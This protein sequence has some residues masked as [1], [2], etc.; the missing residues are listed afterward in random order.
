MWRCVWGW[1]RGGHLTGFL[2]PLC[3][4]SQREWPGNRN[5]W[6]YCSTERH[7][8]EWR[9]QKCSQA[10]RISKKESSRQQWKGSSGTERSLSIDKQRL[11]D[12]MI[13]SFTQSSLPSS[14]ILPYPHRSSSSSASTRGPAGLLSDTVGSQTLSN[15]QYSKGYMTDHFLWIWLTWVTFGHPGTLAGL[16]LNTALEVKDSSPD[17]ATQDLWCS[18][19]Q[20]ASLASQRSHTFS[21]QHPLHHVSLS[22]YFFLF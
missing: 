5:S 21:L 16:I 6:R 20:G 22:T 7:R 17:M 14:Q 18:S 8:A 2:L 12:T 1:G 19:Y 10:S 9:I 4:Q 15:S 11:L 3:S 13:H